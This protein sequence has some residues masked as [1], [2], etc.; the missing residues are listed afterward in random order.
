[1]NCQK[2]IFKENVPGSS[3]HIKCKRSGCMPFNVNDHGVKNG[4]FIFPFNFDPIWAESCSG[5]IPNNWEELTALEKSV[6]LAHLIMINRG[7]IVNHKDN[8]YK[9][10]ELQTSM[11]DSNGIDKINKEE[12]KVSEDIQQFINFLMEK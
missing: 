12:N 10:K 5:Y 7:Q 8:F 6:L 4:W 1:M 9:N 11:I 3:H 2:C